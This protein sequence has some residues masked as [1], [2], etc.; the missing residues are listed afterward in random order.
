MRLASDCKPGDSDPVKSEY[1]LKCQPHPCLRGSPAR[2]LIPASTE[3]D[4]V[5]QSPSALSASDRAAS[6]R[7]KSRSAIGQCL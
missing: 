3:P 5:N 4:S 1:K 7:H 2:G 6:R